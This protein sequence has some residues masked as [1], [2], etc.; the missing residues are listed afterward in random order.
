MKDYI[1]NFDPDNLVNYTSGHPIF[2][3]KFSFHLATLARFSDYFG[4]KYQMTW[5]ESATRL[6]HFVVCLTL[7]KIRNLISFPKIF[8]KVVYKKVREALGLDRCVNFFS[9]AAPISMECLK[10]FLSLDMVILELYGLSETNGPQTM[11][12]T[13]GN[14]YK[15]GTA[16]KT[17]KGLK[18]R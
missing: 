16:G 5:P 6:G 12:Y 11:N 17:L 7:T 13:E 14:N 4:P 2:Y 9:G 8:F 15:L 1:P 3:E 10:Y 18:T